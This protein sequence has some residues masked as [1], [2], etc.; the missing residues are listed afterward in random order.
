MRLQIRSNDAQIHDSGCCYSQSIIP[1]IPRYGPPEFL[2]LVSARCWS[3]L[4]VTGVAW[5]CQLLYLLNYLILGSENDFLGDK[6]KIP[7]R[8][9]VSVW[10]NMQDGSRTSEI[11][12]SGIST[13]TNSL[14]AHD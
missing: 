3:E 12:V 5:V 10:R 2:P 4:F 11:I 13:L 8:D 6:S 14:F 9:V 1:R 7:F